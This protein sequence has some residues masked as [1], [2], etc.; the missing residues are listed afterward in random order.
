MYRITFVAV[1]GDDRTFAVV[2]YRRTI[3]C[4]RRPVGSVSR[5]DAQLTGPGDAG[6]SVY[7]AMIYL[8]VTMMIVFVV[9]GIYLSMR[10]DREA[11]KR[12]AERLSQR[13]PVPIDEWECALPTVPIASLERSLG[14]IANVF[15]V[16]SQHL[17]P[18]DSFH[19]ELTLIDGF[20]CMVID[21]DTTEEICDIFD[22]R[23]GVRPSGNWTDLRE[24]ILEVWPLT[25]T[26][27]QEEDRTSKC[28]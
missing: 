22:E 24:A 8:Y 14:F 23:F 1:F 5:M 27:A 21:D 20:F 13:A 2:E 25:V 9:G 11:A 26:D 19:D 12:R 4:T 7:E 3:A 18:Q 6:R 15:D 17:H 28:S 16:P 10:S